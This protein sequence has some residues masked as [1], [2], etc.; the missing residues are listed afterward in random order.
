MVMKKFFLYDTDKKAMVT[1][2]AVPEEGG[3]MTLNMSESS[4]SLD[5][6]YLYTDESLEEMG[7]S[8]TDTM[9]EIPVTQGFLDEIPWNYT[10]TAP[11]VTPDTEY[12]K[13]YNRILASLYKD[14]PVV[15]LHFM[16]FCTIDEEWLNNRGDNRIDDFKIKGPDITDASVTTYAQ[17][18]KL[19]IADAVTQDTLLVAVDPTDSKKLLKQIE[20]DE[21]SE[22]LTKE[23]SEDFAE[24]IARLSGGFTPPGGGGADQSG[25]LI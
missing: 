14:T 10:D 18:E 4:P 15:M 3:Q 6:A 16:G 23:D 2:L 7:I 17:L 24:A 12:V 13:N 20:N 1:P 11:D 21:D 22:A 8:R 19:G 5:G 9:I 25:E